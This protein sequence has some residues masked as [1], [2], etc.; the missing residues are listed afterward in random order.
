MLCELKGVKQC[1]MQ[2]V[3]CIVK[4]QACR[5]C[6][7]LI[8]IENVTWLKSLNIYK[9]HMQKVTVE[10]SRKIAM[11]AF[12]K[13]KQFEINVQQVIIEK[14]F[15]HPL[16][17]NTLPDSLTNLQCLKTHENLMSNLKFGITDH[18]IG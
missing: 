17:Q 10:V 15:V 12:D 9:N 8:H 6:K 5:A 4:N 3:V 13:M 1:R 11:F 14:F 2:K 7:V 18:L 16:V